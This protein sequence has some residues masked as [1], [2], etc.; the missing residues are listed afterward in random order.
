MNCFCY[1]IGS[2]LDTIEHTFNDGYFVTYVLKSFVDTTGVK[3][4]HNSAQQLITQSWTT[5]YK[6]EVHK[7]LLQ[8]TP[9]FIC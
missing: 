5:K 7:L 4:D 6:Y 1:A 3:I 8:A 9:T 2:G